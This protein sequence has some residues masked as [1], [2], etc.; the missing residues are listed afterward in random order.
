MCGHQFPESNRAADSPAVHMQHPT[1]ESRLPHAPLDDAVPESTESDED[2]TTGQ[3]MGMVVQNGA[4]EA[5]PVASWPAEVEVLNN[6][7]FEFTTETFTGTADDTT[8]GK[9]DPLAA[10]NR[11]DQN[12]LTAG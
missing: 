8:T 7:Q 12:D 2:P 10:I 5:S 9:T 1:L 4:L 3:P 6:G 11:I